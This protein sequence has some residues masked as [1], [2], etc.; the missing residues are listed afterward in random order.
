MAG[1]E[2]YFKLY[3]PVKEVR[4]RETRGQGWQGETVEQNIALCPFQSIEPLFRKLLPKTGKILEA[5]CGLGR[6]VFYLRNLGY[7]VVGIDLSHD[8][9]D[10][11]KAYDRSV[12]ILY[13]DVA[14]TEFEDR[15][16]SAVISLGV[17]EHFEEGPQGVFE[18]TFRILRDDGLFFITVP[19]QNMLRILFINHI[20]RFRHLQWKAGRIPV[21][22]EEYHFGRQQIVT[23]LQSARFE[24]IEIA[25]DDFI[26]PKNMGM[27]ADSRLFQAG[28]KWELNPLG[29]II[30]STLQSLSPWL[31]CA[32]ILCICRKR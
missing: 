9:I 28:T 7:D 31:T 17:V 24:V 20:R 13:K 26:A 12:P 25:P 14:H 6:W 4:N 2:K 27:Y 29:R 3:G 19:F 16:F 22:F 8:A 10:A 32:G 18:E 21:A 15:S 30:N 23:L 5:G 11:A 1:N